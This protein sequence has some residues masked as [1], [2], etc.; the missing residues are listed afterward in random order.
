MGMKSRACIIAFVMIFVNWVAWAQESRPQETAS[1]GTATRSQWQI[2]YSVY[3]GTLTS[4]GIIGQ[5]INA[6]GN[7]EL[8]TA[9][10]K[11][12]PFAGVKVGAHGDRLGIEAGILRSTNKLEVQNVFGVPFP[13][14]GENLT[15]IK[16]DCVIYPL[17]RSFAGGVFR[18]YGSVG[19]GGAFSSVDLDNIGDQDNFSRPLA[20]IGVGAKF[21]LGGKDG[22]V[23]IEVL[24]RNDHIFGRAPIQSVDLRTVSVGIVYTQ[25]LGLQ[26]TP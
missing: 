26:P 11:S 19:L 12:S 14:H 4:S 25:F 20:S 8:L 15:M 7:H 18:P 17:R 6:T 9:K 10:L 21:Q 5:D 2:E 22:V 3:G 23:Q 1:I 24:F 13:N 16:A